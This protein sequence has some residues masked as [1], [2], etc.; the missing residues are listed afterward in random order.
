MIFTPE[1][2]AIL[3][4]HVALAHHIKGRIRFKIDP[5]IQNFADVIDL[6]TLAQLDRKIN[7]IRGVSLNKLA[8]SLTIEYDPV[9]IPMSLW[10]DLLAHN[11][12]DDIATKLNQLIKEENV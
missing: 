9:L 7:G 5:K 2:V 10:E 8:K 6:D 3:A 4:K 12:C 1:N 11:R